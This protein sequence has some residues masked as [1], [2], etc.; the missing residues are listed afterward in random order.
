MG[1][2][3]SGVPGDDAFFL[4]SCYT[5][6][7]S[8]GGKIHLFRQIFERTASVFLKKFNESDIDFIHNLG[9]TAVTPDLTCLFLFY[10]FSYYS[11]FK[12]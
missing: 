10:C 9:I 5:G 4:Q 1:I 11:Y 8:R 3:R 7:Y 6:R 12:G 2:D